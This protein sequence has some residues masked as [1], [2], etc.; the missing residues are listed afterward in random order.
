MNKEIYD[1]AHKLAGEWCYKNHLD[2]IAA[3]EIK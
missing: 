2:M 1:L 3:T